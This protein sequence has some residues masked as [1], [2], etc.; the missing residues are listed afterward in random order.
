MTLGS[1]VS[2]RRS[3][4]SRTSHAA[5][6]KKNEQCVRSQTAAAPPL[7]HRSAE[8]PGPAPHP[9]TSHAMCSLALGKRPLLLLH[10]QRRGGLVR[11]EAVC[12]PEGECRIVATAVE[13]R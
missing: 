3:P 8:S 13:L 5:H 4:I 11:D 10:L 12:E 9:A 7:L 2:L 1:G 6:A